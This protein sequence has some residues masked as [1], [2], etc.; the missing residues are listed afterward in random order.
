MQRNQV[1][2]WLALGLVTA[3]AA[4][5]G[6]APS[7][8]T[9]D[10][11][12]DGNVPPPGRQPPGRTPP[13][14]EPPVCS[15]SADAALGTGEATSPAVAFAGGRFVTVWT[16]ADT[17][18]HLA[19]IDDHGQQVSAGPLPAGPGPKEASV[20]A[21]AGGGF[22]VAWREL[23]TVRGVHLGADGRAAGSA[24]TLA[25][26]TGGDPRPTTAAAAGGTAIA[27][28]DATGVTVGTGTGSALAGQT[29]VPGAGDPALVAAKDALGLV[30][31]TGANVG[32][33]RLALPARGAAPV[34]PVL[35]RD[36]PGKANVPRAA[37]AGSAGYY[38]TWEDDRGG[39]G[40]EA[41]Y[42]TLVG[43]DGKPG[44][45]VSVPADPSSANY[46]D[47]ATVGGYAA[48]VYY[49]FRDGPPAVYLSLVGADLR[50]AGDDLRVSGK[51]ARFPRIASSGDGS[52][53]VVYARKGGP[54]Q[55]TLV[56]CH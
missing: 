30:F 3:L 17:G 44:G 51:G 32:F 49:Q 24:F 39:D 31:T 8:Q 21:E 40:N 11:G 54:A 47:V 35:F 36:A 22:L 12:G 2:S 46:P 50:R 38:V 48:V 37:A 25:Q 10:T 41:V 29:V 56:R 55:L 52:L 15:V 4:C 23:G 9:T 13:S 6:E 28:A 19:M 1:A 42:L 43:P 5:G 18:L 33:A 34:A 7:G 45:E 20:T 53:G 27:W 26:T 16:E 14:G